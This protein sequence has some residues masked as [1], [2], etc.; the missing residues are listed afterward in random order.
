MDLMIIYKEWRI[1]LWKN[2]LSLLQSIIIMN[3][4][5]HVVSE[6][7]DAREA[8]KIAKEVIS[9]AGY[10]KIQI[11]NTEYDDDDEVWIVYA[12]SGDTNM[13]VTIDADTG[14]VTDFSTD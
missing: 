8:I 4:Y 5:S 9:E 3:I 2:P 11:R 10:D 12:D 13:V 1:S 7:S 14:D 6:I